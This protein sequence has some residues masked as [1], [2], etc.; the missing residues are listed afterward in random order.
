MNKGV[1]Q[2]KTQAVQT[3]KTSKESLIK[4]IDQ[5]VQGKD[6]ETAGIKQVVEKGNE[7]LGTGIKKSVNG[8]VD[9][10]KKV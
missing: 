10:V 3:L 6:K 7:S 5:L 4:G 1:T 2:G 8:S 9:N